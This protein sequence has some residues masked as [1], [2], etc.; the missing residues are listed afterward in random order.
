VNFLKITFL[1]LSLPFTVLAGGDEDPR[2]VTALYGAKTLEIVRHPDQIQACL[3]RQHDDGTIEERSKKISLPPEIQQ[4][5]S[6]ILSDN[7]TYGWDMWKPCL[8]DYGARLVFKRGKEQAVIDLCFSCNILS[9]SSAST[10][11]TED[12]DD[13]RAALLKII[14]ESFP[15]DKLIQKTE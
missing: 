9:I 12:F 14:K 7:S 15:K 1:T 10:H 13:A 2:D 3:L 6:K 4:K 5:L 11:T 8:T